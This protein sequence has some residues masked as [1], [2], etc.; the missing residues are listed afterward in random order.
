MFP[1]IPRCS[2]KIFES[3]VLQLEQ[4]DTGGKTSRHDTGSYYTPRPI[5]HYLCREAL[6]VCLE[7]KGGDR[8]REYR[9]LLA[10]DA[11]DGIDADER[12]I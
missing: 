4:S 1:S 10:I 9:K 6:R 5:V 12:T 11:S 2:G 8:H 3:L 7:S